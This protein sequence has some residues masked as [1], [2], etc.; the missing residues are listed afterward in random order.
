MSDFILIMHE[1][2]FSIGTLAIS[3]CEWFQSDFHGILVISCRT[4]CHLALQKWVYYLVVIRLHLAIAQYMWM[5]SSW[6]TGWHWY[7]TSCKSYW[8][9]IASIIPFILEVNLVYMILGLIQWMAR[10]VCIEEAS[11]LNQIS[12]SSWKFHL[13]K[14]IFDVAMNLRTPVICYKNKFSI[15][16]HDLVIH[17]DSLIHNQSLR[18]W[19]RTVHNLQYDFCNTTQNKRIYFTSWQFVTNTD[20]ILYTWAYLTPSWIQFNLK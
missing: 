2:R 8:N 5:L 20:G 12:N 7:H 6:W 17:L 10:G 15:H 13:A 4:V 19:Y 16:Q 14:R 11:E 3:T 1:S 9:W 18:Y